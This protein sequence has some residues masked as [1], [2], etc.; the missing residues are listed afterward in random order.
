MTDVAPT[1]PDMLAIVPNLLSKCVSGHTGLHGV[2]W[3]RGHHIKNLRLVSKE[4]GRVAM[5]EVTRCFVQLGEGA[6]P[7]PQ[8]V[9]HMMSHCNLLYLGVSLTTTSGRILAIS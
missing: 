4:I 8:Q 2:G 1:L 3:S 9:V 5:R 7:E 6:C